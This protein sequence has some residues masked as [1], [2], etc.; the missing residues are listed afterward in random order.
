MN[1]S[2]GPCGT[3]FNGI[4]PYQAHMNSEKHKK[5]IEVMNDKKF[6]SEP[7]NKPTSIS[8]PYIEQFHGEFKCNVCC[9]VLNSREQVVSHIT[10]KKHKK[11]MTGKSPNYSSQPTAFEAKTDVTYSFVFHN[12]KIQN[13]L[14]EIKVFDVDDPVVF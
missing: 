3:I 10:G 1:Y 12:I 9:V 4:I 11:S 5:K 7:V 14:S 2:C 8:D 13:P 6:T